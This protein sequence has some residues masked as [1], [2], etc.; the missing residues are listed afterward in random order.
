MKINHTTLYVNAY[1]W[2]ARIYVEDTK[3]HTFASEDILIS[4]V[5]IGDTL[6]LEDR[7]RTRR[8]VELTQIST[9]YV[10]WDTEILDTIFVKVINQTTWWELL[11]QRIEDEVCSD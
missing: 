4:D 9:E 7:D 3:E 6:V 8:E 5:E 2:G 11:E 10:N 1:N